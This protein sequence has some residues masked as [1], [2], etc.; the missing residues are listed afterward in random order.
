MAL[1]LAV[2]PLMIDESQQS[3]SFCR[4]KACARSRLIFRHWDQNR[5]EFSEA[6]TFAPTMMSRVNMSGSDSQ[7]TENFVLIQ[8]HISYRLGSSGLR[9]DDAQSSTECASET[10]QRAEDVR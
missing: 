6:H 1:K 4:E 7:L 2:R 9:R 3:K 8:N 10:R 5:A